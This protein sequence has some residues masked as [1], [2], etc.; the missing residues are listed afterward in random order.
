METLRFVH[1]ADLHLDSPFQGLRHNAP[2]DI[3]AALHDATFVAYERVIDLCIREEAQALLVAGDVYDGADRSLR[4]QLRFLDGLKRLDQAGIHSF[5]CHGNHDPLDGWTA[6]LGLPERCHQFGVDVGAVPLGSGSP[7]TVY[8][9]SY[10][11]AEMREDLTPHF[12]RRPDDGFAIGLLHANVGGLA[13]HENY[14]PC[15]IDSLTSTGID[16][17]ALGHV[18][19]RMELRDSAPAIVYPGNTQGRHANEHGSRGVYVVDVDHNN[20]PSLTYEPVCSV[21][22]EAVSIDIGGMDR[23]QELLDALDDAAN[24]LLES[25]DACAVV[26]RIRLTGRGDLHQFLQREGSVDDLR[27]QLNDHMT[28]RT[29]FLWCERITAETAPQFDRAQRLQSEDF[30]A[31]VLR[32]IDELHSHHEGLRDL[33]YAA[34]DPLYEVSRARTY[35]RHLKPDDGNLNR[36]L[37]DAES[38]ILTELLDRS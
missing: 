10:P 12:K 30:L 33:A 4:A 21:R 36:L 24:E 14:A 3:A 31:D 34:I 16:Y 2:T 38:R 37:L 15:T 32:M 23:E 18:H 19:T 1:A 27:D 20:L 17:W 28:R 7:A 22:W 29:P 25:A 26:S 5:V 35:L 6:R 8:G 9:I 11:R 13:E